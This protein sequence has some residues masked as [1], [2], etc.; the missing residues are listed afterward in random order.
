MIDGRLEDLADPEAME[1]VDLEELIRGV[2]LLN[3]SVHSLDS[4]S[5]FRKLA[6]SRSS[7]KA[8]IS[9]GGELYESLRARGRTPG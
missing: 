6:S 4:S 2:Y 1:L 7:S 5:R 9:A 3:S 8:S